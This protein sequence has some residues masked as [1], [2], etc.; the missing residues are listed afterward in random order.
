[1]AIVMPASYS[2]T[3]VHAFDD[4]GRIT[5]PSEWRRDSFESQL[6]LV[7]TREACVRVYPASWMGEI[8]LKL[9][10]LKD[11]DPDKKKMQAL[12]AIAQ[13]TM[14]DQQGR[15]MVKEK[16]RERAGLKPKKEAVLVGQ[17]GHFEIWEKSAYDAKQVAD[18][19]IEEALSAIGQ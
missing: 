1:M 18:L 10:D 4:K 17:V 15:I 19:T 3:F 14:W 9:K 12:A 16:L 8:Q 5:V 2:D 6:F 7:P 11:A 13:S